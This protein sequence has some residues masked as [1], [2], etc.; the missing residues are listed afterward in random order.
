MVIMDIIN[1]AKNKYKKEIISA[2]GDGDQNEIKYNLKNLKPGTNYVIACRL[3]SSLLSRWSLFCKNIHI[4][5]NKYVNYG[6]RVILKSVNDN[7]GNNKFHNNSLLNNIS[8]M[9]CIIHCLSN[10]KDLRDYFISLSYTKDIN[11]NIEIMDEDNDGDHNFANIFGNILINIWGNRYDT[12]S[13]SLSQ[14]LMNKGFNND[15]FKFLSLCSIGTL[16]NELNVINKDRNNLSLN[17][18]GI[19]QNAQNR[20]MDASMSWKNYIFK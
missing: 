12:I 4:K 19:I 7:H 11:Q 8:F 15:A 5:T 9:N 3:Y 20:R 18:N 6:G 13:H 10:S 1:N 2:L 17:P 16:H 14:L